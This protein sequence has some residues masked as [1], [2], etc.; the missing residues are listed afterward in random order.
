MT[1]P[2]PP[3]QSAVRVVSVLVALS[4]AILLL[5]IG[6]R[7]ETDLPYLRHGGV[8]DDPFSR[9]YVAHPWLTYLHFLP[10]MV[11]LLGACLQ[12]S[13]RVRRRH[14]TLHRRLGR[15]LVVVGLASGVLG[16]ALG[17]LHPFGGWSEAAASAVFGTWFVACLVLAYLAVRRRDIATHRR[18]MI[19]AFAVGLGVA[20]IR[21]WTGIFIGI[22]AAQTGV[23]PDGP[24][25]TT[26]GLAFWVGF[27]T[28]ALVAEWWLRRG[29]PSVRPTP[30]PDRP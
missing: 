3:R 15:V 5:F 26:F 11:F 17:I 16:T 10:G 21:V 24:V 1:N 13:A 23:R 22:H 25:P 19:R 6:V 12:V 8:P 2:R 29:R 9:T 4:L 30:R 28:N 27:A 7:F 18:W 20:T 14:L